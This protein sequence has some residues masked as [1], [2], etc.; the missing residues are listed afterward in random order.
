MFNRGEA[1]GA[2]GLVAPFT[3]GGNFRLDLVKARSDA[4]EQPLARFGQ[5]N[6]AGGAGEKPH[7]E[8][9]FQRA[10]CVAERRLRYAELGGSFGEALLTGNGDEGEKI[11]QV[12]PP[13][14]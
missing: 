13:H 5:R 4:V 11:V 7:T 12:V 2:C 8:A 1:E 9:A 14:S 3:D 10:H 6:A